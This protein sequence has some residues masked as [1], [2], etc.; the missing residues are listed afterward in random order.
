MIDV[1][2]YESGMTRRMGWVVRWF[3]FGATLRGVRVDAGSVER[4]RQAAAAGTVVY[5]L[6]RARRLD[7]LAL[8]H[9]LNERRLPIAMWTALGTTGWWGPLGNALRGAGRRLVARLSGQRPPDPIDSGWLES[10]VRFGHA[11]AIS[12]DVRGD[13]A[14]R[15]TLKAAGVRPVTWLP[16]AVLWDRGPRDVGVVQELVS[17]AEPP[18]G[19]LAEWWRVTTGRHGGV[20]TVGEGLN[21]KEVADRFPKDPARAARLL[22]HRALHA[23]ERVVRGPRLVPYAAMRHRVLDN[24]PMRAFVREEAIRTSRSVTDVGEA[25][26]REFRRIAAHFRWGTVR[27]LAAML[28]PLWNR[29]FSGIDVRPSDLEAIRASMRRGSVVVV[30]CHKSHLDYLLLSWVFFEYDLML[31]HIVA[32]NNLAIWPISTLLRGGGA[33]FIKRQ[34]GDDRVHPTVFERYLRELVALGYPLE[35][36]IEGGRSRTGRLMR[37]K[38]GVLS[39]VLGAAEKRPRSEGHDVL[40]L[41]VAIAYEQVAEADAYEAELAGAAKQTE[42]VGQL[43]RARSILS[44]RFGRVVLRVGDAVDLG[45]VVDGTPDQATWSERSDVD[46]RDATQALGLKVVHRIGAAMVATPGAL[47]AATLL[48]HHRR[49][50]TSD[51]LVA[52][53]ARFAAWVE[54]LGVERLGGSLDAAV[55]IAL[56]R[57]V[58]AQVVDVASTPSGRIWAARPGRR[59]VLDYHK[60]QILHL[61]SGPAMVAAAIRAVGDA[62]EVE[63]LAGPHGFV[64][65][66]LARDLVAVAE[67]GVAAGLA[68]LQAHG[69]V[70]VK[71]DTYEVTDAERM[72]EVWAWIA[73]LLTAVDHVASNAAILAEVG[74]DIGRFIPRVVATASDDVSRPEA[75]AAVPLASA[76]ASLRGMGILPGAGYAVDEARVADFRGRWGPMLR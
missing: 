31:P 49:G 40:L 71:G 15:A 25:V 12:L 45:Q 57:F 44:R 42:S 14:L 13:A 8:N 35:F 54:R 43:V 19:W 36:F 24:P 66:V 26:E 75:L 59:L 47:V 38:L 16:V 41:P 39:M 72:A 18:V 29:V 30:P 6:D 2:P 22:L 51:V 65:D 76:V 48:V 58:G 27:L 60:N 74:G 55:A 63:A 11:V 50:I 10:Q 7:H 23:E 64:R 68:A 52:R 33:F 1:D 32:G 21:A 69:A 4:I 37:P 53:S 3:G 62:G 28:R 61:F 5:V 70:V 46:R 20:I 34:F 73:D 56:D 9:V 17:A 67:P